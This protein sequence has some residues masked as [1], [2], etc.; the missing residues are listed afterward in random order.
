MKFG[1]ILIFFALNFLHLY[2]EEKFKVGILN[3]LSGH[4]QEYGKNCQQGYQIAINE[5]SDFLKSKID[6]IYEDDQSTVKSGISAFNKLLNEKNLI[7]I[8]LFG[9]NIGLAVNPL[10]VKAQLPII[11]LTGHSGFQ[12][13]NIYAFSPWIDSALEA[14]LIAKYI[15]Q[16]DYK[17]VAIITTEN[18]YSIFIRKNLIENLNKNKAS[19]VYDELIPNEIN[20]RPLISKIKARNPELIVVNLIGESFSIFAR[21]LGELG[22]KLDLISINTNATKHFLKLAGSASATNNIVFFNPYYS[23]LFDIKN[24]KIKDDELGNYI[25]SCYLGMDFLLKAINTLLKIN[26]LNR[27][28]LYKELSKIKSLEYEN[29]IIPVKDRRIQFKLKKHISLDYK[30]LPAE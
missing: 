12:K 19:I 10:S 4:L 20:F 25:F 28:N 1:F 17:D 9:A 21:Q 29:L 2:A 6:F 23:E 7:S 16:K 5:Q 30:I 26:N 24:I 3:P 15:K 27:I 8:L 13:N 18:E 22:N 14:D 11:G